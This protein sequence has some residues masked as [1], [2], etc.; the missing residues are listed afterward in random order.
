MSRQGIPGLAIAVSVDRSIVWS[1][2]FG[3]ADLENHVPVSTHTRFRIGS[4]SK[5]LTAT[6]AARLH[7]QGLLDLDAPVQRYVPAFPDKAQPITSRE[8]LGHLAGVRHYRRDEYI[9]RQHYERVAD[10]L[11]IFEADALLHAPNSKYLYSSYG[12]V[13]LGAVIEGAS[14]DEYRHHMQTQVFDVLGLKDTV[15]DDS[16]AIV[17]RRTRFYARSAE[18]AIQ[19][20]HLRG[21]QRQAARRRIPLECP[22]PRHVWRRER[23]GPLLRPRNARPGFHVPE[24]T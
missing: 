9:N 14:K 13:L 3:V 15:A 6:A 20:R 8:L 4:V 1:E 10:S 2:G 21:H 17:E 22:R 23:A 12:Y 24:D 11:K 16:G 18:G 19:Q 7:Q 5:L